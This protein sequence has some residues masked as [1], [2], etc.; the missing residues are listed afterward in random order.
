VSGTTATGAPPGEVLAVSVKLVGEPPGPGLQDTVTVEPL[1]VGAC[2]VG[3]PGSAAGATVTDT[4]LLAALADKPLRHKQTADLAVIN[5]RAGRSLWELR[6]SS[7]SCQEGNAFVGDG[8][9]NPHEPSEM[10]R[11]LPVM[12][13]PKGSRTRIAW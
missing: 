8:A 4:T 11:K 12:S 3:A 10:F 5:D 9:N 6:P 1:T 7:P 13:L 2:N